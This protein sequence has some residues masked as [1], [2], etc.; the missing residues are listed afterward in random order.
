MMTV[1]LVIHMMIAAALIGFVLIQ[2]S[3]GGALGIGGG[4]GS[5]GGGFMTGR[6]QANFLT[7]S[8]SI[9]GG[10]FFLT[11]LLLTILAQGGGINSGG[12]LLEKLGQ[13]P[14][15][16]ATGEAKPGEAKPGEPAKPADGRSLLDKLKDGNAPLDR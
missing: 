13:K 14:G 12:S 8:T 2:K 16:A 15:A 3:E 10:A 7:R 4:G 6:G 11:S 5:G 9:L 1:L